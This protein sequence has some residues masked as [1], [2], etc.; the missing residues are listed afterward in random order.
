MALVI[1]AAQV[2][3]GDAD[4]LFARQVDG[5]D[6]VALKRP[7]RLLDQ[8]KAFDRNLRL[9][10]RDGGHHPRHVPVAGKGTDARSIAQLKRGGGQVVSVLMVAMTGCLKRGEEN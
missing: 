2:R 4:Q 5:E 8:Q 1:P 10:K 7:P 6:M 3:P 9:R